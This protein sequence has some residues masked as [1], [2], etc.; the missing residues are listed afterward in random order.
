VQ[1]P[2]EID[3]SGETKKRRREI[4]QEEEEMAYICK[5]RGYE[6]VPGFPRLGGWVHGYCR[7]RSVRAHLEAEL[8]L[9][10]VVKI[11]G[12]IGIKSGTAGMEKDNDE[13]S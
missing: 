11:R 1:Y 10:P 3:I 5:M 4:S 2:R 9:P 13:E 6:W 7:K 8:N 12:R